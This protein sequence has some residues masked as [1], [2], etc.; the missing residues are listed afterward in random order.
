VTVD[1]VLVE[2]EIR[3]CLLRYCRGVDRGDRALICSAFHDDGMD[4]HGTFEGLGSQWADRN[5][6]FNLGRSRP[7]QHFLTNT[8]VE[9]DGDVALVESYFLAFAG[10]E[11]EGDDAR[12]ISAGRY[13]DRFEH[14]ESGW[15]I[16]H[17]LTV[18][19]WSRA[20]VPGE[21]W[22]AVSSLSAGYV[23]GCRGEQ[24]PSYAFFASGGTGSAAG[25]QG[26]QRG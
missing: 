19:D 13:L 3:A 12:G 23:R 21:L 20:E 6:E 8:S 16:A 11:G 17:R 26:T 24:D 10:R 15:R 1:D 2:A 9:R 7:G 14:R 25:R 18:I 5:I 4:V 22:D